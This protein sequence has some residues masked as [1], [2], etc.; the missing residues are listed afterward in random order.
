MFKFSMSDSMSDSMSKISALK[1]LK[2]TAGNITIPAVLLLS[3][4]LCAC[5]DSSVK[6]TLGLDRRAPDEFKVISR[7]PLSV[8]PQFELRPPTVE[9]GF[10]QPQA[11][12]KAES[13]LLGKS[14][15]SSAAATKPSAETPAENKFL[16]NIGADNADPDVK[17]KLSEQRINEQIKKENSGWW[18][19]IT[20]LPGGNE[21]QVKAADEAARIKN[22]QQEGKPVTEGETPETGGGAQSVLERLIGDE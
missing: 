14:S 8:P 3:V 12:E 9:A 11:S 10:N 4:L 17:R 5:G 22:N 19:K 13:L 16:R 21:P 15:D 2:P 20:D 18:D 7:P 1:I 6:E